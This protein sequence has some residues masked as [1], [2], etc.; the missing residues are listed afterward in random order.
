[1][2]PARGDKQEAHAISNAPCRL[3][4]PSGETG[5]ARIHIVKYVPEHDNMD[6]LKR[7]LAALG[8]D[9]EPPRSRRGAWVAIALLGCMVAATFRLSGRPGRR[10]SA[11]R[12]A[13]TGGHDDATSCATS[14]RAA[15][16]HPPLRRRRRTTLP[17]HLHRKPA[18]L[19]LGC[20]QRVHAVQVRVPSHRIGCGL[21]PRRLQ[22]SVRACQEGVFR[23]L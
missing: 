13:T 23:P 16:D 5:A 19:L 17:Q 12:C 11:A 18:V 7:E 21:V 14:R 3:D 2:T 20:P 1:M 22:E 8:L 9:D 6:D 4:S 15:S 10:T